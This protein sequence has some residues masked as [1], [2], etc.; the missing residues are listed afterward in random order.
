MKKLVLFVVLALTT[1]IALPG[2]ALADGYQYVTAWGSKGTGNGQFDGITAIAVDGSGNLYVADSGNA[3]IEKFSSSGAFLTQWAT[4]NVHIGGLAVDSAGNVYAAGQVVA[5]PSW[6]GAVLK[7]GPAGAPLS[8]F[9]TPG[10]NSSPS[11]IAIDSAGDVWVI[12]GYGNDPIEKFSPGGSYLGTLGTQGTGAGQFTAPMGIAIDA[13]DNIYVVDGSN[14]DIQKFSASGTY[15]NGHTTIAAGDPDLLYPDKVA[16]DSAGNAYVADVY[17]TSLVYDASVKKFDPSFVF[18]TRIGAHSTNGTVTGTFDGA[19]GLA[20]DSSGGAV[21]IADSTNDRIL[22]FTEA[23][24]P[25]PAKAAISKLTPTSGKRGATITITGTGFGSARGTSTVM[26][27][28]K[29]CTK[30]V[31]WSATRIKVKV[32]AKAAFGSLKVTVKTKGGTSN[33]KSFRVLR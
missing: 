28:A 30:Y 19:E 9:K 8:Q 23:S 15:L 24:T 3:R 4:P 13:S 6:F 7:Y 32:P 29:T 2:L 22:K 11:A 10:T 25:S 26:F 5:T 18:Q 31:S 20:V 12:D 1:L 33:A 16:V 17:S 21:Y 27:G 14:Y